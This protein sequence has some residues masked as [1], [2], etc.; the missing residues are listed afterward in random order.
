MP[1]ST[2]NLENRRSATALRP[3]S[4]RV[5]GLP[6][7]RLVIGDH[8]QV[9]VLGD[10]TLFLNFGDKARALEF[11]AKRVQQNMPGAAVKS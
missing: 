6:N 9:M 1:S 7:T 2:V 10:R 3:G 8:G 5:E 4:H 11:L